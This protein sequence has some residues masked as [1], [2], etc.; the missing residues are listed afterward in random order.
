MDS[1]TT[2]FNLYKLHICWS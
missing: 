1:Y 2:S